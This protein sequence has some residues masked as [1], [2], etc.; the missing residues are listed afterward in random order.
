[1]G[2]IEQIFKG[3]SVETINA[4]RDAGVAI[5]AMLIFAILLI[6]IIRM[7]GRNS[8]GQLASDGKRWDDFMRIWENQQL[9]FTTLLG[10]IKDVVKELRLSRKEHDQQTDESMQEIKK[11]F[12]VLQGG[13]RQVHTDVQYIKDR[14]VELLD[15]GL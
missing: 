10:D 2:I 3:V 4:F 14:L 11:G 12:E 9:N 5:S 7:L 15:K 6:I 1:M 8:A 13:L